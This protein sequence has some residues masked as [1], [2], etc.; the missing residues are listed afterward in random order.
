DSFGQT[1]N[2]GGTPGKNSSPRKYKCYEKYWS[3]ESVSDGLKRGELLKGALRISKRNFEMAW[4]SVAGQKRDVYLE[5]V[6]ARNRALD[7]DIVA[8]NISPRN[9]WKLMKHEYDAHGASHEGNKTPSKGGTTPHTPESSKNKQ[10]KNEEIPDA[11]LQQTAHVVYIIEK[12]HTRAASGNLKP[13]QYNQGDVPDGLF[14]PSDSRLPRMRIP[15]AKCPLGFFDRPQDFASTLFVGRITEWPENAPM[16]NFFATGEISRSLGEAGEI[17][18]ET[19]GIF[20]EYGID[21][22]PFP[23]EALDCLPKETPWS[24]PETEFAHRR[25]FRDECVFTIDPLTARD[26]DDALHCKR[27]SDGLIE[28]GVHIADVSFFVKT[29]TPLDD[30]AQERATSTY[31]VQTVVPMLPRRLCEELCSL[32]PDEDRLTFSVVWIMT[33]QGEIKSDWKGRGIIRSRVKMAYE[34]AQEMIDKPN[35][36]WSDSELPPIAEGTDV[37]EIVK[38]VNLLAKIARQLRRNRFEN[39]ALRL[40]QVKLQFDLDKETGMPIGYHVYQQR[41]SNKL[42]EEF[43]LLA[44][45]TVAHHIYKAFPDMALLRRHPKPHEKQMEDLLELCRNLG[46]KYNANSSKSIQ[47]SL[48]QFPSGSAQHEILVQLT[49]KPMK[50]ALYFCAGTV[51]EEE[52][53]HYALSVP[54]YTHFTSPIRRYADVIVHRLLAASLELAEPLDKDAVDVDSIAGHCNDCKLAAKTAGELSSE[55]FFAIFVRECGPLEEDGYVLGIMDMS[56]DVFV[57]A[58]GVTKRIYCKFCP[59]V[60]RYVPYDRKEQVQPEITLVWATGTEKKPGKDVKQVL[61]IFSKVHVILTT[62]S[63]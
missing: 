36:K 34:H 6:L 22:G 49:M 50:N 17:E 30:I 35:K 45:M 7:G 27:L 55:L 10:R 42:I 41:E 47:V 31:M 20:F 3:L 40:D 58:L 4:V 56:F 11:Y 60:K 1:P 51:E 38:R 29:G 23:D 24:I 13:F 16:D 59:G 61:H 25:D 14:S 62:E 12:K 43:M 54:L 53:G 26:L 2:K 5:G 15:H 21:P 39:G 44:N 63:T 57:P 46:I 18:P 33:D 8:L 19:Q 48:A 28:V 32:N 52:Y 37:S 9:K